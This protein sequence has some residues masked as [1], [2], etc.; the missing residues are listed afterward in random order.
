MILV[1]PL[2]FNDFSIFR[3]K[4]FCFVFFVHAFVLGQKLY[5]EK[6][7]MSFSSNIQKM[8]IQFK[9]VS[10]PQVTSSAPEKVIKK[11]RVRA[12]TDREEKIV[13]KK[14]SENKQVETIQAQSQQKFDSIIKNF[15]QPAYPRVA[16][17]RGITGEVLLALWIQGDGMVKD[18]LIEKSSGNT[19]LDNS[20]L[21]A[22]K[23]WKFKKISSDIS[24]VYK[25]HK[26]IVYKLN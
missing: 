10:T 13:E 4:L 7:V 8:T 5:Q 1:N 12:N 26:R 21:D 22:A 9:A 24:K 18:L 2:Q 11:K 6:T 15:V 19:S 14:I 17:R 23:Y 16:Q 25:F 20:V 3:Y